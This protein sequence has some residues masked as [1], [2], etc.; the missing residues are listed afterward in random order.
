M[1]IEHPNLAVIDAVFPDDHYDLTPEASARIRAA[2]VGRVRG[3]PQLPAGFDAAMRRAT[4]PDAPRLYVVKQGEIDELHQ[5]C[6]DLR[7][8]PVSVERDGLVALLTSW[9]ERV[10]RQYPAT[11]EA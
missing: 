6:A 9:L 3:M 1:S 8:L 5:L 4:Q 7:L 11:S 10:E 2:V